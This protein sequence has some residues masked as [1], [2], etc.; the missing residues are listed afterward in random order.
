M[1]T[2]TLDHNAL[3]DLEEKREPNYE[4]L[5]LLLDNQFSNVSITAVSAS[6]NPP[7]SNFSEFKNKISKIKE[8]ENVT[9]D[10]ILKPMTICD[11]SFWDWSLLGDGEGLPM[12][13]L[14]KDIALILFPTLLPITDGM[15]RK[16]RNMLA[17]VMSLWCHIY[18]KRKYFVT[19]DN[20]FHKKSNQLKKMATLYSEVEIEIVNPQNVNI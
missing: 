5:K 2:Y 10:N 9:D 18:H 20:N 12:V 7:I 8:I 16:N 6:E 4:A 19:S 3:I 1:S 13:E 15:N 11:F 17:D 14:K